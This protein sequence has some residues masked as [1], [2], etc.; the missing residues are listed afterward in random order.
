M[1][2]IRLSAAIVTEQD[3]LNSHAAIAGMALNKPVI[4]NAENATQLLKSGTT[5]TV[6]AMRGIVYSGIHKQEK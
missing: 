3:G 1:E 2:L 6:D 4:V 5:V